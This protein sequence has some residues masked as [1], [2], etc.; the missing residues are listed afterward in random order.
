MEIEGPTAREVIFVNPKD[1]DEHGPMYFYGHLDRKPDERGLFTTSSLQSYDPRRDYSS[2]IEQT[3]RQT[4][5]RLLQELNGHLAV[6]ELLGAQFLSQSLLYGRLLQRK[7]KSRSGADGLLWADVPMLKGALP[8]DLARMAA[9]DEAVAA[10]RKSV[11]GAFRSVRSDSAGELATVARD[12]SEELEEST[13]RLQTTIARDRT[14][15]LLF[16][17][18]LSV[19]SLALGALASSPLAAVTGLPAAL[20]GLAPYVRDR[21]QHREAAAYALLVGQRR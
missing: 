16:P 9:E 12:L 4:A 17:A 13:H 18:G 15:K 20:A 2:W 1:H 7:R 21:Q 5:A 14:W 19:G 8:S 6:S 11:R 3:K 10:L